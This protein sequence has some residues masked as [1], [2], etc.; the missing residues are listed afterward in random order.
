MFD[1]VIHQII[2]QN[3]FD[4]EWNTHNCERHIFQEFYPLLVVENFVFHELM[5]GLSTSLLMER[6][7]E[8]HPISGHLFRYRLLLCVDISK[9]L[10]FFQ[11]AKLFRVSQEAHT[12]K[13]S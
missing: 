2:L 7:A 8:A 4:D 5:S 6:P 13:V 11:R 12:F 1:W 10:D 9:K 3:C